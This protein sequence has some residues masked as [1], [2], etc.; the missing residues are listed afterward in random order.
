MTACPSCRAALPEAAR[1]CP[2][3]GTRLEASGPEATERKVVTTLFADLV[4]FTALGERY[5]PEDIDAALRGFYGLARTIVERFGGTVEKFIGDAVVGLFGV[6]AAHEDDAERA[7]RA[8]I[9]LVAHL[10]ELPRLGEEQLQVR[11]AVNT[12]PALV[13]LDARPETGEGVLVG[14]AVNTCARLL[15][16]A[17]AM[18]V[19]VGEMTQRLSYRSIAYEKLRAVTVKGKTGSVERWLARGRV[20]RRGIAGP[21]MT[22]MVAREVELATLDGLLAKAIASRSPQY[23]LITGEAG[24]GK[25]RLVSEFFRLVDERPAF[26]V[27]WRQGHCPPYGDELAYWLLR[28]VFSAQMGVLQNDPDELIEKKLANA[29]PKADDAWLRARLRPL[30]GLLAPHAE[31]SESFEAWLQFLERIASDMPTVFVAEDVHWA[32]EPTL[33]FLGHVLRHASDV[34]L[35]VVATA[36]PEFLDAHQHGLEESGE[37]VVRL[38]LK[39]LDRSD[40]ARLAQQLPAIAGRPDLADVVAKRS[41]G[42]PLFAEELAWRIAEEGHEEEA[43]GDNAEGVPQH[44]TISSLIAARVDALP[45]AQRS[46]LSDAAVVGSIFWTD[47][48]AAVGS[49]QPNEVLEAL[50]GLEAREF[51]RLSTESSQSGDS[52]YVFW[53]AL[54]RDVAYE[55]LPRSTRARKHAAVA[56]WIEARGG[57]LAIESSDVLAHHRWTAVQL[58][59]ATGELQL[60]ESLLEPCI[61]ALTLAGERALSYDIEI[62]RVQFERALSLAPPTHPDRPLMLASFAQSQAQG[63]DLTLAVENYLEAIAGLRAN[64]DPRPAALATMSLARVLNELDD[65]RAVQFA[66]AALDAVESLG[67]CEEHAQVLEERAYWHEIAGDSDA[68]TSMIGRAIEMRRQ[69]GLPE[70]PR[71]LMRRG[72]ARCNVGDGQAALKD[73]R[74]SLDITVESSSAA[75]VSAA[76]ACLAAVEFVFEGPRASLAIDSAGIL[77]ARAHHNQNGDAFLTAAKIDDLFF[78]GEWDAALA[79]V[80]DCERVLA[81][82]NQWL[83]LAGVRLTKRLLF[84]LR[85]SCMVPEPTDDPAH[86][87]ALAGDMKRLHLLVMALLHLSAREISAA[88]A[89]LTRLA[90]M[91]AELGAIPGLAIWWPMA[92]RAA[93]AVGEPVLVSRLTA[94][95]PKLVRE[96]PHTCATMNGVLQEHRDE[97]QAAR[98]SYEQAAGLWQRLGVPYEEAHARFGLGRCLGRLKESPADVAELRRAREIFEQLGAG[99][100]LG[101]LA[102]ELA[103]PRVLDE[104]QHEAE[105]PTPLG[106]DGPQV[107]KPGQSH[108]YL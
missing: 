83:S 98:V 26:F 78:C 80:V 57:S 32:S 10:H 27:Q 97:V 53:H 65:P 50:A 11:C 67:S 104:R 7:V 52:E 16:G 73:L 25:S 17:P 21:P 15:A 54:L 75:D 38:G 14:D 82:R 45:A 72:I 1:F 33:A 87:A 60:H 28:E 92:L 22:A 20:A 94:G 19:V 43:A 88:T 91:P 108:L 99:P 101:D 51:V 3:C 58:A 63:G 24:I 44:D 105:V 81:R 96:L 68:A 71:A 100:D 102:R 106:D 12:G 95:T 6:P 30:M 8:G 89:C 69:L 39:T 5:D 107:L 29:L 36:R 34:P 46:V 42:N 13:R 18:G 55:R 35:L 31:R 64:S 62:A 40:S 2:S 49:R 9:E 93:V 70:S 77:A 66:D 86:E 56:D 61:R 37:G 103:D 41:G 47:A 4:G 23:A 84:A 85:G 48:I 79:E 74:R 59:Q 76:H 90:A